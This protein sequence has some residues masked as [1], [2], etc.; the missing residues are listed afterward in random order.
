[1]LILENMARNL[2][3]ISDPRTGIPYSKKYVGII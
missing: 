3:H 1:M 2:Y